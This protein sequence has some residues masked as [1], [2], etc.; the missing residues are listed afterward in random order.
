MMLLKAQ[1]LD[2]EN[3]IQV[4]EKQ[5]NPELVCHES[6]YTDESQR[7]EGEAKWLPSS[8]LSLR[9]VCLHCQPG[10]FVAVVGAVGA[11]KVNSLL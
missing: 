9:R 6:L 2:A 10:D 3:R 7:G 8:L 4:L 11:G 1:L 5:V